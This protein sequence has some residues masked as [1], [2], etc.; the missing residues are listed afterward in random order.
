MSSPSS[1]PPHNI[2]IFGSSGCGKSSIINMLHGEDIA[3]VSSGARGCTFESK[4]YTI[5]IDGREY[6]IH[7][8]AGLDEGAAGK[9][10]SKEAISKLYQLLRNLEGGVVLL[11]YCMRGPRL[12]DAI[13]RNYRIFYEGF[14]S[15]KVPIVVAVTGLEDVEPQM[16]SWWTD[17]DEPGGKA[18]AKYGMHFDGHACITASR[19]KKNRNVEEYEESKRV[20]EQL[21]VDKHQK[22]K[23]WKM[24]SF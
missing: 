8:T 16:E 12:T 23:P 9:V 17:G 1:T 4:P 10:S 14:C 11:I 21:I 20:L 24:V 22:G 2:I 19:G 15:K 6:R 3:P 13:Q 5:I 7:D 18:F